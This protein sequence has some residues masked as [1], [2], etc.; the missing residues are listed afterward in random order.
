MYVCVCIYIYIKRVL[1]RE[2]LPPA[3]LNLCRLLV[4]AHGPYERSPCLPDSPHVQPAEEHVLCLAREHRV[5]R[6]SGQPP[7]TTACLPQLPQ[8]LLAAENP[9]KSSPWA[10][11][12][13][14][15]AMLREGFVSL[16]NLKGSSASKYSD[17][18]GWAELR[19]M[20][21]PLKNSKTSHQ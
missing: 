2:F 5:C 10:A 19:I 3:L 9:A 20:S 7:L 13:A 1:R 6:C 14:Q 4:I 8:E 12:N 21:I 15:T 17:C 16:A 11:E 18:G